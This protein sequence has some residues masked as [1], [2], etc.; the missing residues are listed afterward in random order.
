M[1]SRSLASV[2]LTLLALGVGCNSSKD[3]A[4]TM[5]ESN[6]TV[7]ARI[8]MP[9]GSAPAV[10]AVVQVWRPD[11]TTKTPVAQVVTGADGSYQLPKF[12]DGMY[13]LVARRSSDQLV[14]M[15][16][17]LYTSNGTLQVHSDTL[18]KAGVATGF[19]K[20]VGDDNP[21]SVTVEVMGTDV[22]V[23][24]DRDG[25]FTF[26]NLSSGT[27]R[28]RLVTNLSDYTTTQVTVRLDFRKP[29]VLDTI[30]MNFAGIPPVTGFRA[31][32]DSSSQRI[33]LQW[34]PP[35]IRGIRDV[36]IFR[37]NK[38]LFASPDTVGISDSGAF[39]DSPHPTK[40]TTWLYTVKARR[41]DGNVGRSAWKTVFQPAWI[42]PWVEPT[43]RTVVIGTGVKWIGGQW[44]P[45]TLLGWNSGDTLRLNSYFP[46]AVLI[47]DLKE[48]DFKSPPT[49][50]WWI[51]GD[52]E[53]TGDFLWGQDRPFVSEFS[54]QRIFNADC[55][56]TTTTVVQ[57]KFWLEGD[58]RVWRDS[59][60]VQ[61]VHDSLPPNDSVRVLSDSIRLGQ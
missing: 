54:F 31:L 18:N 6:Q 7:S 37:E 38:N 27:Y 3:V 58:G 9:G 34:D 45:D 1:K 28:L 39:W 25:K 56:L 29:V 55:F 8:L 50:H 35:L 52:A 21:G 22:L 57:A 36:E 42:Q 12:P 15:R 61:V 4:G 53:Q 48:T 46:Q 19:V 44:V 49:L 41:N 23:N 24:V 5:D 40:P 59:V 60:S 20:M 33:K 14:A 43:L 16:D 51:K 30:T 11:D 47:L 17:S 26:D 13:R 32:Y 10:G 2:G